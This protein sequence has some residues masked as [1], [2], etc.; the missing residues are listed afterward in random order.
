MACAAVRLASMVNIAKYTWTAGMCPSLEVLLRVPMLPNTI[1]A[2][3][4]F[5]HRRAA[6][7]LQLLGARR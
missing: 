3:A 1:T 5:A 2:R 4:Y 6:L 7:G